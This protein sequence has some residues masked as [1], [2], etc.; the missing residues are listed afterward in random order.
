M[1]GKDACNSTLGL[2]NK[3]VAKEGTIEGGG[4]GVAGKCVEI[5]VAGEPEKK[6]K[7]DMFALHNAPEA[8]YAGNN[9]QGITN[10]MG[11]KEEPH[12]HYTMYTMR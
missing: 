7:V 3:M 11:T 6:E 10:N 2:K 5:S 4:G 1:V 8:L 12:L 9:A